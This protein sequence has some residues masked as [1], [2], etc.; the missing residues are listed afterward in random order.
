MKQG[1]KRCIESSRVENLVKDGVKRNIF[2]FIDL[3]LLYHN[4]QML[5]MLGILRIN[6]AEY[7]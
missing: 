4:F 5:G 2:F 6:S 1:L 7:Q 3:I